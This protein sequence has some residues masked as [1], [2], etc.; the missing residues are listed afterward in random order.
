MR[1]FYFGTYL[2]HLPPPLAEGEKEKE[3]NKGGEQRAAG[4][5]Q[6]LLR[7]F[8]ALPPLLPRPRDGST[9]MA[10]QL[11]H[12]ADVPPI[13]A[14]LQCLCFGYHWE[15]HRFP[16]APWFDLPKVRALARRHGLKERCVDA[17]LS[18]VAR[19]EVR[20]QQQQQ[21]KGRGRGVKEVVAR[22][23]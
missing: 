5:L 6:T 3:K 4:A 7:P 16:Y 19:A 9:V 10:W 2:P 18:Q 23:A 11:S 20:E 12:T 21:N 13:V 8:S 1:L 14:F 22:S 15:H 17:Y